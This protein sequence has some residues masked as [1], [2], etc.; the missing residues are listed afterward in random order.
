MTL[1][2]TVGQV[3]RVLRSRGLLKEVRGPEDVAILG[4]SQDSRDTREGDL[5]LAWRGVDADAHDYVHEAVRGGAAAVVVERPV[6]APVPQLVVTDGRLAG[7]LA[8]DT[9]LGSP[10][11]DLILVAVTG[12][13][14]KTTTVL[15]LRHL[16]SRLGPSAAIGTLGLVGA[17]G[18][19]RPGTEGLTTPG[20]VRISSW[21]RALVDE[22]VRSVSVEASSHA[23]A[24]RRLDALRFDAGVFTNLGRDHLDYHADAGEYL[25]AKAR[26]L[27]LLRDGGTA[28]VNADEP[29]WRS[30][31]ETPTRMTYGIG[32]AGAD[33]RAEELQ[34]TASGS[35]FTLVHEA[36][37]VSTRLPL[38]GRFN[39]EN[40]LAAAAAALAVGLSLEEV[41]RGLETVPQI[42]G[43]LERVVEE[44]APVLIDFAHTPDALETVLGTLRPLVPGRLIVVFGAGGDRD[45]TK[46]RPMA[47]AV[48]RWADVIVLTS[49]NPRTENPEVILDDLE[50]GLAGVPHERIADRRRAIRR[51]LDVA[52]TQDLVML[53]GKGHERYQVVGTEKRPLDERVVVRDHLAGRG[54]A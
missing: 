45:R 48:A 44:P 29:A 40:A 47:E 37:R 41:A 42:P 17:D 20:P 52:R 14:G 32:P 30:L 39:V 12:T 51:A 24:Q 16:L 4:V 2:T 22:G 35:S 10:G 38:L 6:S 33:L 13:N 26:L 3:A 7:A 49:D 46:R 43:R 34:L 31:P 21:L 15:M 19:V 54:A 25:A 1:P 5:F 53:A 50:T 8:A 18:S 23:L 36:R 11:R 27:D 9:V 28:V